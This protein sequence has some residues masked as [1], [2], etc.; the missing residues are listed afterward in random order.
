[1]NIME[2]EFCSW[3]DVWDALDESKKEEIRKYYADDFEKAVE[4]AEESPRYYGGPDV[5]NGI[6][7]YII[8]SVDAYIGEFCGPKE[9]NDRMICTGEGGVELP[10]YNNDG[11]ALCTVSNFL[12]VLDL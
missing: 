2:K 10:D 1:M 6:D 4:L 8:N 9:E 11:E 12:W 7:I 5:S 3:E